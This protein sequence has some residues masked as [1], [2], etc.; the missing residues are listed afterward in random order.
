MAKVIVQNKEVSI[1][2]SHDEDYISLTDMVM[3]KKES[4]VQLILSKIG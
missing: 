1:I 2:K 3:P 4:Q